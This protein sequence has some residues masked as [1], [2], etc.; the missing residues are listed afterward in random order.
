MR[1][2]RL[3]LVVMLVT[4]SAAAQTPNVVITASGVVS[5]AKTLEGTLPTDDNMVI[6]NGTIWQNKALVQCDETLGQVIKYNTTTNAWSCVAVTG[7]S[8]TVAWGSITGTLSSQTDLQTALNGKQ[9]TLGFTP[10]PNTRTVNGLGL[11]TDITL[12]KAHVGLDQV[13]NTSDATKNSATVILT[14]KQIVPRI[15]QLSAATGTV[16]APSADS[17]DIYYRYDISGAL[18]IPNPTATGSNP[19]HGQVLTFMFKSAAPQSITWGTLFTAENGIGL[20]GSTTGDGTTYDQVA[21]R[22]NTVS[23]KWGLLATTK[24]GRGVTPLTSS[25][26][27]TC[28]FDTSAECEMQATM[29]AGTI[30]VAAPT[31]TG[32]PFNGQMLMLKF[33]CTNAQTLSLNTIF[34]ASP[35]VPLPTTCPAGVTSWFMIGAKYSTVLARWQVIATN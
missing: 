16:A 22:Y 8:G 7:G 34:I 30:T 9:P 27:Y 1:V 5:A 33:L 4:V 14:N 26:T 23:L 21:F 13:D 10:V 24:G 32:T 28:P 20:F 15:L 29:A 35:N 25:T 31:G 17:A 2:L 18:T 19:V 12:T 3:V 11:S 6:G